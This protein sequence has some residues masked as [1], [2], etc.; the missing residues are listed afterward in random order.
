[1][2]ICRSMLMIIFVL[3]SSHYAAETWQLIWADEFNAP[4][5]TGADTTK[6]RYNL[7]EPG[8]VNGESQKYTDRIE[9]VFHD[10]K[11]NMVLRG[12]HDGWKGYQYTSGRLE[13]EDRIAFRYTHRVVTRAKMPR[14]RG[15]WPAIWLLA[16]KCCWPSSGEIDILEQ[17]GGNKKIYQ[18]DTHTG[19]NPGDIGPSN[20]DYGSDAEASTNFHNYI[21]EWYKDS[22]IFII[23]STRMG[24][25]RYNGGPFNTNDHYII[26][27]VALGGMMGGGIDNNQFPMDMVVDW[28][29]VYTNNKGE[30]A[31][32]T[33]GKN[34]TAAGITFK[35]SI[36][37]LDNEI[38]V[39]APQST[40][41]RVVDLISPTGRTIRTLKPA[42]NEA[43][44]STAQL[45]AGVYC[46][47][48]KGTEN[49]FSRTIFV[50][51]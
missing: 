24:A 51:R 8:T 44:L 9:N 3:A 6:W 15:S 25:A 22:L 21:V 11:G 4:A 46:L 19:G 42:N 45:T 13:S 41:I 36:M 31:A 40:P 37:T 12:L 33:P 28:V 38:I 20:Y 1:V 18:C 30:P 7:W 50:H 32:V 17:W 34:I 14:G 27:N 29:R 26:L 47:W 49:V 5:N 48:V 23:D 35:P 2:T 39:K 16:S 43:R 10:G